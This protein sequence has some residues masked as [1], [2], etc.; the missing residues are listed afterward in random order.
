[1]A[2]K[3][4]KTRPDPIDAYVGSRV[5]AR[6]MGLRMSQSKLGQVIGVTFQQVQ[7]YE[8]GNNR[9]GASNLFKI[10]R[11]LG[12]DVAYMYEGLPQ[13]ATKGTPTGGLSEGDAVAFEQDPMNSR[14]AI[15]LMHNYFRISAA[16]V[17]KKLFQFVKS[18]A[19]TER[20][21]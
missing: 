16:S 11:A 15:E 2:R 20:S 12:V 7:K 6:R 17:R 18:M 10:S 19:D 8:N 9:I 3:A 14:E 13:S 1:M 21:G 4:P 5:R